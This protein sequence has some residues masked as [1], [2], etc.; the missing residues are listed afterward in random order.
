MTPH[1]ADTRSLRGLPL[2]FIT[3]DRKIEGTDPYFLDFVTV[4]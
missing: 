2:L 4:S 1:S 3:R